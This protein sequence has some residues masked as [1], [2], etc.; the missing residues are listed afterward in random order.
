[1][2]S[3]HPTVRRHLL[4][5]GRGLG[6]AIWSPVFGPTISPFVDGYLSSF[7]R[8]RLRWRRRNEFDRS[9]AL[10]NSLDGLGRH[11]GSH[12]ARDDETKSHAHHV[13]FEKTPGQ[14]V[15][16][17][18]SVTADLGIGTDASGCALGAG[19]RPCGTARSGLRGGSRRLWPYANGGA[20]ECGAFPP[21]ARLSASRRM[22]HISLRMIRNS[23]LA[24]R[25]CDKPGS[26]CAFRF[27]WIGKRPR[28]CHAGR[29][30]DRLGRSL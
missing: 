4:K 11:D 1:M 25:K 6:A 14:G 21:I 19:P 18:L 29:D 13:R 2:R 9:S 10:S 8:L 5:G 12:G 20:P 28:G 27:R 30:R 17:P 15:F 16:R 22:V 26:P 23:D 3:C 7:R 24:M